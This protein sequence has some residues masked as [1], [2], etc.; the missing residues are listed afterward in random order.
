M[1][2][3]AGLSIFFQR[4]VEP[5]KGH[6]RVPAR[7]FRIAKRFRLSRAGYVAEEIVQVGLDGVGKRD[8]GEIG[9]DGFH[10]VLAIP[11]GLD[12]WGQVSVSQSGEEPFTQSSLYLPILWPQAA[13][14][15]RQSSS[16]LVERER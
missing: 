2:P 11:D 12:V 5:G 16:H 14:D 7:Q 1:K 4:A 3:R 13:K 9:Q 6:L 15:V 8:G 10:G